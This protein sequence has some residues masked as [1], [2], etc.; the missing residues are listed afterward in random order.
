METQRGAGN[1]DGVERKRDHAGTRTLFLELWWRGRWSLL[2]C[3]RGWLLG[4]GPAQSHRAHQV[5][6][7]LAQ[8][9]FWNLVAC[10][11]DPQTSFSNLWKKNNQTFAETFGTLDDIRLQSTYEINWHILSSSKLLYFLSFLSWN[12]FFK[13]LVMI[14]PSI[15]MFSIKD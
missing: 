4:V 11:W 2:E 15:R 10:H 8:T 14:W 1:W 3:R 12:H 9:E 6:Q 7:I 13:H 5:R